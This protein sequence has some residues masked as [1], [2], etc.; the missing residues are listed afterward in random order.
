MPT[1]IIIGASSG[2][3]RAL[4]L[5][6]ARN[7]FAVGLTARR[8]EA[9]DALAEEIRA[10]GGSAFPRAMDVANIEETQSA[11]AGLVEEMER[12]TGRAVECVVLNAAVGEH[13]AELDWSIEAK[14]IAVNVTGTT[15]LAL[16]AAQ[17]FA[18]KGGGA[19]VGVSSIAALRGNRIAPAYAASKAFLSNYLEGL[20]NWATW[21]D[22]PLDVIDIKPGFVHTPM[23]AGNPRVFWGASAEKAARQIYAAIRRRRARAYITKRWRLIAW[24]IRLLPEWIY[25]RIV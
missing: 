14:T 15:A 1:V 10:K 20:R 21:R 25:N 22:I 3:G 5:E 24:L 17:Y 13:N 16:Q 11:F 18:E 8:K 6:F 2:I 23:T 9:L 19:L 12:E 7:S 4:A